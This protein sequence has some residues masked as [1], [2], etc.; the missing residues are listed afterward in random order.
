MDDPSVTPSLRAA[1]ADEAG[2][3]QGQS[4]QVPAASGQDTVVT[5]IHDD[6]E[7]GERGKDQA[8]HKRIMP[9]KRPNLDVRAEF[10]L[11]TKGE[12]KTEVKCKHCKVIV[13]TAK[14]VNTSRL[15]QHLV[16]VD[17]GSSRPTQRSQSGLVP[18]QYANM[19]VHPP[20]PA[21]P[22][23]RRSRAPSASLRPLL[24]QRKVVAL[25]K[26]KWRTKTKIE[27]SPKFQ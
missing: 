12:G 18:P 8:Q 27:T 1:G 10:D 17:P 16:S 3:Q 25:N 5:V 20:L 19:F 26:K 2:E 7:T 13:Q 22:R 23:A 14:T 24:G 21:V 6:E 15:R 4:A 9:M 11:E